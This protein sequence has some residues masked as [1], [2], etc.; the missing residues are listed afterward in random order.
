MCCKNQSRVITHKIPKFFTIRQKLFTK[1][2]SAERKV[3]RMVVL[4]AEQMNQILQKGF[5][6]NGFYPRA[7]KEINEYVQN[8]APSDDLA[9]VL[10]RQQ[11]QSIIF[12]HDL[13]SE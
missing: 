6:P 13:A 3:G 11:A 10:C 7:S 1:K 4:L 8:F 2:S 5:S 12:F 9:P